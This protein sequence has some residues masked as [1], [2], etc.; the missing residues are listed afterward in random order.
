MKEKILFFDIDGTLWDVHN[1]IPQ[2]TVLAIRSAR[3][4][5]H[6]AFICSGRTRGYIR[7]KNLLDIGFDG[8]VSG[9]GTMLEYEGKVISQKNIPADMLEDTLNI[10]R[11]YDM[12]PILEGPEYLYFDYEDFGET[13]Y[14]QKL[15]TELGDRWRSIADTGIDKVVSKLS[16]ESLAADLDKRERCFL[17]LSKD[18]DFMVHSDRVCEVV[19][20]GF[21]KGTGISRMCEFLGVCVEDSIAFG[22][23][24]NDI[25]M[26]DV[27]GIGVVM[28]N[29]TM[30][31]KRH[32]DYVTSPMNEDGILKAMKYL[33]ILG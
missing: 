22:D 20:K 25:H 11:R 28:G 33:G 6:K 10:V 24:A 23:S 7:D 31:A 1:H 4:M 32:A 26:L 5:G 21:S 3:K 17:E 18:Y 19:P 15:I 9:C 8:V 12:K 2:S 30:E 14:G 13:A 29:G 16:L 27:A